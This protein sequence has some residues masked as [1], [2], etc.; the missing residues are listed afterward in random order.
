MDPFFNSTIL[1]F[2]QKYGAIFALSNTRGGGDFGEAWHKAGA[3]EKK[4]R[5]VLES[6]Q[7]LITI[8]LQE[9]CLDDFIAAT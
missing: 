6:P 2:L 7:C 1:T 4:V 3:N 9:N 8:L 5:R